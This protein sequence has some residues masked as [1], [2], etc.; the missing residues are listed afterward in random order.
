MLNIKKQ[1][2]RCTQNLRNMPGVQRDTFG[3][4]LRF[5]SAHRTPSVGLGPFPRKLPDAQQNTAQQINEAML[6]IKKQVARCSQNFRN[7][8]GVQRDTFGDML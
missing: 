3:D 5:S 1:L 6:N 8:P 2:A 7:M 4:M